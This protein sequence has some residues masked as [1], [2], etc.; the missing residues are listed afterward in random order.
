MRNM[1]TCVINNEHILLTLDVG[2][3]RSSAVVFKMLQD[4]SVPREAQQHL[5][6]HRADDKHSVQGYNATT[7]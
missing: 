4:G 5:A 1:Y 2:L 6:T 3:G 7:S